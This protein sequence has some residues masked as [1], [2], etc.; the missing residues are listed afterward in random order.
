M[1]SDDSKYHKTGPLSFS[2]EM[3]FLREV[4]S[5]VRPYIGR[6]VRIDGPIDF[7]RFKFALSALLRIH[8]SLRS[9]CDW[10]NDGTPRVLIKHMDEVC[11]SDI[12]NVYSCSSDELKTLG[13]N[14]LQNTLTKLDINTGPVLSSSLIR[15]SP[16][17][18]YWL[19][20]IHHVFGDGWSMRVYGNTFSV[21]YLKYELLESHKK[22][23]SIDY[24][25]MQRKW[26]ASPS[27][28]ESFVWWKSQIEQFLPQ[29]QP[30]LSSNSNEKKMVREE[31]RFYGLVR[32]RL[33]LFVQKKK[34]PVIAIFLAVVSRVLAKRNDTSKIAVLSNCP[35]R[36]LPGAMSATGAFYNSIVLAQDIFRA[37][38]DEEI[39]ELSTATILAALEHQEIPMAV[40]NYALTKKGYKDISNL[41]PVKLNV[42]E[43]PFSTFKFIGCSVTEVMSD[44]FLAKNTSRSTQILRSNEINCYT[45]DIACSLNL[46]NN[47]LSVSI[48]YSKSC[49]QEGDIV[50]FI[51]EI[52][53]GLF[54]MIGFDK[55][56]NDVGQNVVF[57]NVG[58]WM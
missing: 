25:L 16:N 39:I 14:F 30:C 10:Q 43:H 35:G 41:I 24:A 55:P 27:A 36:T 12:H 11:L 32:Q 29:K 47:E 38:S 53:D 34:I 18:C 23:N 31:F 7:D 5:G 22:T 52:M 1:N 33:S 56:I 20:F 6:I 48:E 8:E 58:N 28:Q 26:M 13:N 51:R 42:T 21:A 3:L 50:A 49:Y 19:F 17:E 4:E 46:F 2:Q 37:K 44:N 57:G 9:I 40:V 45:N 54:N 15:I